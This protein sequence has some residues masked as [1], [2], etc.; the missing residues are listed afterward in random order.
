MDQL[1][2]WL[3]TTMPPSSPATSFATA[4]QLVPA[5]RHVMSPPTALAA[6][7]AFSVA[8]LRVALSCSASTRVDPCLENEHM[9]RK[10]ADLRD[11]IVY[12]LAFSLVEVNQ[13]VI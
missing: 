11:S 5:T 4:P 2:C 7:M 12:V 13:A 8:G 10:S 1:W 9:G 3:S 6:V